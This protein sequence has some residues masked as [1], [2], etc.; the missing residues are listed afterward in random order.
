[1]IVLSDRMKYLSNGDMS[2]EWYR[3]GHRKEEKQRTPFDEARVFRWEL[4]A[5]FRDGG[6]ELRGR[7]SV[8]KFR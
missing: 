1:M 8:Y 6:M 4:W 5:I 3:S 7:Q 2:V